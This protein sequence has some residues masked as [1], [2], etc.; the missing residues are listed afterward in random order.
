MDKIEQKLSL[1]HQKLFHCSVFSKV[2]SLWPL[3]QNKHFYRC[4]INTNRK[5]ISTQLRPFQTSGL[6][7]R[8]LICDW[9][10]IFSQKVVAKLYILVTSL[11]ALPLNVSLTCLV[12]EA[13]GGVLVHAGMSLVWAAVYVAR[14]LPDVSLR[15]SERTQLKR[16]SVQCGEITLH[17]HFLLPP[18]FLTS[19]PVY[20]LGEWEKNQNRGVQYAWPC[21][22]GPHSSSMQ[23]RMTLFFKFTNISLWKPWRSR[24][25]PMLDFPLCLKF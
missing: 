5:H 9:I 13:N 20:P 3:L 2:C 14:G 19:S 21:S 24:K 22:T 1:G 15:W 12:F 23:L 17:S 11:P 10:Y 4:F 25:E 16:G 6:S 7:E 8:H 18:P